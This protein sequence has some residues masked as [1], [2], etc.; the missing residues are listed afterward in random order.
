MKNLLLAFCIIC[1]NQT[2]IAQCDDIFITHSTSQDIVTINSISCNAGGSHADN[3][4]FRVFD[5]ASFGVASDYEVSSVDFGIEN[6]VGM[7][8]NQSATVNLYTLSG[9]LQ[10]SNLTLIHTQDIVI[11]DQAL[12]LYNLPL[13]APVIVPAGSTLVYELFTPNGQAI[14]NEFFIGS[15]SGGESD[16]S[17]IVAADCNV[18]DITSLS[19][20][21]FPNVHFVMNI[22]GCLANAAGIPTIGQWGFIILGMGMLCIGVVA[23]RKRSLS[24]S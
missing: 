16:L 14:G 24:L 21:N 17:Y 12:T 22:H 9:P 5:L 2:I 10:L 23:S 7:G 3:G 15:N 6:A 4:Y 1:L 8:G 19:D 18:L 13:S 11:P 20:I